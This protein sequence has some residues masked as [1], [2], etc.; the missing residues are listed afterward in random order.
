MNGRL[1]EAILAKKLKKK[2]KKKDRVGVGYYY[3]VTY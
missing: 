1:S 3:T 2:K